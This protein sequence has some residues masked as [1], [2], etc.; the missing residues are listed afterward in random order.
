MT[1]FRELHQQKSPF[2]LGNVWDVQSVK[3]FENLGFKA[4]GTSSAAI[5]HML[6][7]SDGEG[8]SFSE[9]EYI[10]KRIA[11][12]TSLPLSVDIEAG[13]S[14]DIFTLIEHVERLYD[15]GIVGINLEDSQVEKDRKL[16][17][18]ERFGETL[19]SL[20]HHLRNQEMEIFLNART[21]TF[22]LGLSHPVEA[23]IN[24]IRI[25]EEAGAD[26]IFVPFIEKEEDIANIVTS[27][28]LPVNVLS[29]PALPD[30]HTLKT[31]GVKRISMGNA[32]HDLLYTQL[33]KVISEVLDRQSFRPLF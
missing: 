30:F 21:D 11:S 17:A 12:S 31:L 2:L 23:T 20:K 9:L 1:S 29:I 8:M 33:E 26:G 7:Y 22:L 6:G 18:A 10:V 28:K 19:A 13:Y 24:R 4:L 5:A 32:A 27:T 14:R 25:Y 16:V 15:L 3:V